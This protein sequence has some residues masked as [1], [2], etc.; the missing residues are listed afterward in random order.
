MMAPRGYTPYTPTNPL[1]QVV[2][3]IVGGIIL[4]GAVLMGA[5]ILAIA[6]GVAIILGLVVF[7]RVW[8]LRRKLGRGGTAAETDSEVYEVEYT[9]IDERDERSS[10]G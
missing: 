7:V 10:G 3:F 1:L 9:V 8:W 5:V 4:I 6:L 2:Y